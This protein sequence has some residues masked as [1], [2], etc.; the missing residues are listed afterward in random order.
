LGFILILML[1][2]NYYFRVIEAPKPPE[3]TV[4]GPGA[5]AG[6]TEPL[7]KDNPTSST[8]PPTASPPSTKTAAPPAPQ[9]P[10]QNVI[11]VTDLRFV[12]E[13]NIRF[14]AGTATNISSKTLTYMEVEVSLLNADGAP[15]GSVMVNTARESKPFPPGSSWRFRATVLDNRATALRLKTATGF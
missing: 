13:N 7:A 1:G 11:R 15:T 4:P 6:T 14:A 2:A 3:A 5:T 12:T 10:S 8:T 9:G